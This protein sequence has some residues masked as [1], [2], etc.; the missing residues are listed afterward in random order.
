VTQHFPQVTAKQTIRAFEKLGFVVRR[1]T[2]SH[3]IM[4]N[5]LTKNFATIPNHNGD[6]HRGLLNKVLKQ[7]GVTKE[8]FLA[9][10]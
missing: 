3:I 1:Q 9:S 4:R 5:T 10:L 2:G 8:N 6:I 7:S